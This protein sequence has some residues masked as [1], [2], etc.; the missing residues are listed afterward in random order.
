MYTSDE[1]QKNPEEYIEEPWMQINLCNF[2]S[3]EEYG[4]RKTMQ[5]KLIIA[6]NL[7]QHLSFKYQR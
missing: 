2:R 6:C 1:D 3:E 7:K 4:S 5:I